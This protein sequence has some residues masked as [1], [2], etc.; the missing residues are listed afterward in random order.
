MTV[1][2]LPSALGALDPLLTQAALQLG[3]PRGLSQ[4]MMAQKEILDCRFL[5]K[6]KNGERHILELTQHCKSVGS[7]YDERC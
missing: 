5:S 6:L 7:W 3:L 2:T 1:P 4:C